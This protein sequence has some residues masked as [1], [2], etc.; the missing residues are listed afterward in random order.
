MK[1]VLLINGHE[2]YA[3]AEGRFNQTMFEEIENQLKKEFEI[4]KTIIKEGY[5][6]EEEQRKFKDADAIIFQFPIYWFSAPAL[7]K[8]YID[9]VYAHGVFFGMGEEGKKYGYGNGLMNGKK[10]MFSITAN[11]PE[12]AYNDSE[13]FFEG[14]SLD[15]S[16]FHMHKI[17][18]FCGME[19][20]KSFGAYNVIKDPQAENDLKRLK[21]HMGNVI[22]ELN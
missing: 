3:F 14:K 16:L 5:N 11:S 4:T 10:Y 8:K 19:A 21:E 20:L 17:N 13:Q 12:Y 18:E 6:P 9:E 22:A 7:M 15:E 2:P 1:K